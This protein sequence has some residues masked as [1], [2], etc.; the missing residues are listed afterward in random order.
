MAAL[1]RVRG[2][3]FGLLMTA[4]DVESPASSPEASRD[5]AWRRSAGAL[6]VSIESS[7]RLPEPADDG[8]DIV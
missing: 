7:L 6:V 3:L 5:D 8:E 4:C 2:L 1:E